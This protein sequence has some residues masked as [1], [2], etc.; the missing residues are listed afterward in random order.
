MADSASVQVK[1]TVTLL[2]YQPASLGEVVTAARM[3]GADLL[4]L[5]VTTLLAALVL[6]A[7]SVTVWAEEGTAVPS[8]LS[9]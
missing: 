4:I 3:V 1:G 2:L 9:V 8:V 7:A 6:P 5:T